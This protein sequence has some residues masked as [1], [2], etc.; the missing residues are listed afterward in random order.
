MGLTCSRKLPQLPPCTTYK[1]SH[2]STYNS[3]GHRIA[4]HLYPVLP[5][6][7]LKAMSLC[8]LRLETQHCILTRYRHQSKVTHFSHIFGLQ[9]HAKPWGTCGKVHRRRGQHLPLLEPQGLAGKE[10]QLTFMRHHGVV[11]MLYPIPSS[12]DPVRRNFHHLH[13]TDALMRSGR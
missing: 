2:Q 5:R 7:S 6:S 11:S 1:V 4:L 13:F 9:L 12:S 8:N 3:P 10:R